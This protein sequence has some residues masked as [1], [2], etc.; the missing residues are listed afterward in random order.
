VAAA[1]SPSSTIF[2]WIAAFI[3]SWITDLGSAMPVPRVLIN[4]SSDF[5]PDVLV[6]EF[7]HAA[8]LSVARARSQR[9]EGRNPFESSR[10]NAHR[11][12]RTSRGWCRYTISALRC[13]ASPQ[14]AH[15]QSF[16]A[17]VRNQRLAVSGFRFELSTARLYLRFFC[18][19]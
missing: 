7:G 11:W 15:T 16:R 5:F 4:S 2:A 13:N 17:G 3:V 10:A 6:L 12:Q 1:S 8:S 18:L 14:H 19:D 9:T